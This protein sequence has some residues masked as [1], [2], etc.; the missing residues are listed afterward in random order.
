MA[1]RSGFILPADRAEII[2]IANASYPA[3]AEGD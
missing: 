2:E 1:I 3:S